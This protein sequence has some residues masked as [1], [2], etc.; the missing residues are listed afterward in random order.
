MR[1]FSKI[2]LTVLDYNLYLQRDLIIK[3][4]DKY[5]KKYD[6]ATTHEKRHRQRNRQAARSERADGEQGHPWKDR[7]GHGEE[8]P[9]DGHPQLWGNR[10]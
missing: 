3:E 7:H 10:D 6:K 9:H 4:R 2:L 8:D 1:F 5:R